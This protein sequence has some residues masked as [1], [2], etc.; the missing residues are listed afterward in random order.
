ME[1]N[2]I[3]SSSNISEKGEELLNTNQFYSD[4]SKLMENEMFLNFFNKYFTNWTEIKSTVTFMKLYDEIKNK[5]GE[6]VD[7]E[8]VDKNIIIFI[9]WKMMRNNT[10]RPLIHS[11]IDKQL[12]QKNIEFFDELKLFLENKNLLRNKE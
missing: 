7:N 3:L 11:T 9:I 6:L 12:S 10:W 2:I 4:L 8:E 5:Y 1:K